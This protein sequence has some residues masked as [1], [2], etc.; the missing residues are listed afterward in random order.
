MREHAGH[1]AR[2]VAVEPHAQDKRP[3]RHSRPHTCLTW[4][5][6]RPENQVNYGSRVDGAARRLNDGTLRS[7]NKT[8]GGVLCSDDMSENPG[9]NWPDGFRVAWSRSPRAVGVEMR[10]AAVPGRSRRLS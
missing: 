10:G 4:R 3:L 6:L 8:C 2:L 5:P 9:G 7:V 1:V